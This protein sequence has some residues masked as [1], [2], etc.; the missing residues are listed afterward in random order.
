MDY[1]YYGARFIICLLEIFLFCLWLGGFAEM[2]KMKT[3]WR[4]FAFLAAIFFCYGTVLLLSASFHVMIGGVFLF[5]LGLVLFNGK[6]QR[7]LFYTFLYCVTET[8]LRIMMLLL[9][10]VIMPGKD[11]VIAI[12]WQNE[13]CTDVIV[14]LLQFLI[15]FF[16]IKLLHS[17]KIYYGTR[18]YLL[19]SLTPIGIF[20]LLPGVYTLDSSILNVGGSGIGNSF[21]IR[22]FLILGSIGT[23]VINIVIIYMLE[24]RGRAAKEIKRLELLLVQD[25]LRQKHYK[26]LETVHLQYDI[27]LHDVRRMIRTIAA[28]VEERNWDNANLLADYMVDTVRGLGNRILC[29]HDILNALLA[30][31]KSYAE[32]QGLSMEIKGKEPLLLGEISEIDMVALMGNLLDNAINAEIDAPAKEGILCQMST[33]LDGRHIVIEVENSYNPS[34]AKEKQTAQKPEKKIERIGHK[35]GIGLISIQETIEKYGGMISH[36]ESAGRY[37]VKVILS[38]GKENEK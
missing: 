20:L 22:V 2:R 10:E 17:V 35:H 27:Y 30:E 6:P 38:S 34:K 31:R 33:A 37:Y 18:N 4:W 1:F 15:I 11:G 3:L 23:T 7:V 29:F 32:S 16:T 28:M 5:F 19:F 9:I 13:L 12:G 25:E 14:K 26:E 24:E 21:W 8:A 36:Q